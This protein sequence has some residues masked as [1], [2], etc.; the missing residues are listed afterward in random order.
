[1]LCVRGVLHISVLVSVGGRCIS[2]VGA[3]ILHWNHEIVTVTFT[4]V[5]P[6]RS[7]TLSSAPSSTSWLS[8]F[9]HS[10]HSYLLKKWLSFNILKKFLKSKNIHG[11]SKFIHF[12][13]VANLKH[14]FYKKYIPNLK[15]SQ[16]FKM[17]MKFQKIHQCKNT[18]Y[19]W[20]NTNY[21]CKI[22]N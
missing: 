21:F 1:M 16:T 11:L 13:N 9:R 22:T 19:F 18:N 20:K 14:R 7:R 3:P 8:I 10:L 17:F 2:R 12:K 15:K 4:W 6:L 5:G